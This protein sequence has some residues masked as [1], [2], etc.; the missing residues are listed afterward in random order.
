MQFLIASHRE[1]PANDPIFALD[2]EA[3]KRVA[4]GEDII[5]ATI[6]VL[7]D[8]EGRLAVM[9][10]VIETLGALAPEVSAAYAPIPGTEVFRQAVIDDLLAPF[11][12]ADVATGVAS[13]GGTGALRLAID[14]FLEPHQTL[15]TSSYFW[16]PYRTLADEAGRAFTTFSMFDK[17]GRFD[18]ADLG[19]KLD[20]V[21]SSQGRALVV[22]NTPCHNPTGYSLD[23]QEWAATVDA[24]TRHA[25]KTPIVLLIDIAYSYYS[26]DN[27]KPVIEAIRPIIGKVMV[28]F[29]WSASKSFLQYG[30]RVGSLVVVA[31]DAEERTRIKSALTF[32]C[33]GLWSNCNAGGMAA[34]TK[35]LTEPA[36]R[37]RAVAERERSVSMLARRVARWNDLALAA[38]IKYPRYDG[39]FF[40]TVFCDAAADVAQRLRARGIY[41]VPQTGAL[42]VAMCAINERQI[43]RVVTVLSEELSY[44]S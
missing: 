32:S 22:L 20:A 13:P 24:L 33:R 40:T 34:I 38:G 28:A 26:P 14:N 35:V 11:G 17:A 7:L 16:G 6:G 42:R 4:A 36:L 21:V 12:L 18:A 23:P 10:A 25:D 37:E 5:N 44:T 9:P 1:R 8:D 2:A 31:P 29:A 30:L 19:R 39:G 43:E 3:R 15:L 27:L 41:V